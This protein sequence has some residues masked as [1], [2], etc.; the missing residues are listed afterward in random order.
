MIRE[1]SSV[2]A[3]EGYMGMIALAAFFG[4]A[5][6]ELLYWYGLRRQLAK[7]SVREILR[8]P[9]Y[10]MITVAMIAASPVITVIMHYDDP[11]LITL[12]DALIYGAAAP[13]LF[14]QAL[15][16]A[17]KPRMRLPK[18]DARGDRMQKVSGDPRLDSYG[19]FYYS[20][21]GKNLREYLRLA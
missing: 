3:A 14:K 10:W 20:A 8:S 19:R 9:G 4:A 12:R 11:H 1:S 17:P 18:I 6:Q 7:K 13:A 15:Q 21:L 16:A 2:C 5:F